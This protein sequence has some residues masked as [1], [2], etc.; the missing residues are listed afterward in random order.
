[1]ALENILKEQIER[2]EKNIAFY[3]AKQ[4][5]LPRGSLHEKII[6]D[7]KYYYLKF[8]DDTGHRIDQYVKADEV[9]NIKSQIQKRKEIEK[10]IRELKSDIKLAKKVLGD[11]RK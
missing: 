1:M 3:K 2:N 7:R 5:K 9:E 8:R 11:D 4:S 6:N 10:I